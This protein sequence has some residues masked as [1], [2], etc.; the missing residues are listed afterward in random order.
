MKEPDMDKI[1]I[2]IKKFSKPEIV[3]LNMLLVWSALI[4]LTIYTDMNIFAIQDF[5]NENCKA[6]GPMY[7]QAD[8]NMTVPQINLSEVPTMEK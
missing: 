3:V 2:F 1:K 7:F 6:Y 4:V 5:V 8:I